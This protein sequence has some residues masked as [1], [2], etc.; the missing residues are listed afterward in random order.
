MPYITY[1]V[2]WTARTCPRCQQR[3]ATG[4]GWL[5]KDPPPSSPEEDK[6]RPVGE[7]FVHDDAEDCVVLGSSPV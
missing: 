4:H 2:M 1:E 7:V 3:S 5:F 6:R